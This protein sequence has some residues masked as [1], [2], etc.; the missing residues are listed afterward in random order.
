MNSGVG[1]TEFFGNLFD[2]CEG[3]QPSKLANIFAG[4]RFNSSV[5]ITSE[6]QTRLAGSGSTE[7]A[8]VLALP[9]VRMRLA[10]FCFNARCNA[11]N[12][13]LISLWRS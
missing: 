10:Y 11:S 13:A 1:R 4:A 5:A 3:P 7:L 12:S 6:A 8:E 2:G 9:G